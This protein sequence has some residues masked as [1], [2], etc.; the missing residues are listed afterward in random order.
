MYMFPRSLFHTDHYGAVI[1]FLD[2]FAPD[3][4]LFFILL[5][6]LFSQDGRHNYLELIGHLFLNF[7]CVFYFILISQNLFF[8]CVSK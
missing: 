8:F 2:I 6:L 4:Y 7:C 3:F 1:L 5:F